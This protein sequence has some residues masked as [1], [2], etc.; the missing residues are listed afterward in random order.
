MGTVFVRVGV[1]PP[2]PMVAVMEFSKAV[3]VF[4]WGGMAMI[5]ISGAAFEAAKIIVEWTR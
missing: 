2:E 3:W 5:L 4:F 1:R